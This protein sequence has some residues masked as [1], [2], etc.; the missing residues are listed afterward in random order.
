MVEFAL[1]STA[2]ST[3]GFAPFELTRSY[4]PRMVQQ[5]GQTELPGVGQF[6]DAVMETLETAHDSII[7]SRV[8]QTH[9]A[10]KRRR[11]ENVDEGKVKPIEVGDKVYLATAN[12][13]LPKGRARKLVPKFIG[14]YTVVKANATTSNYTIDLPEDLK[15]RRIHPVFHVSRLRRHEPNDDTRFPSREV[16][17]Y[18]DLG[19]PKDKLW[20]VDSIINHGKVGRTMKFLVRWNLGDETWEPLS[21]VSN[22]T[23]L[24]EYLVVQGAK[25]VK[26]LRWS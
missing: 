10:N 23:A 24:D 11:D 6:A 21:R 16:N 5:V 2:S 14:P 9:H 17:V 4:M 22:L 8:I 1:N 7:E 26:D 13:N 3:T 12:L 25:T 18:Y 15:K 20:N 19:N